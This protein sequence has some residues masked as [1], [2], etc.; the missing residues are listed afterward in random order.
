MYLEFYGT[1]SFHV[2]T[3]FQVVCRLMLNW[4]I[5]NTISESVFPGPPTRR[6]VSC[7]FFVST[8]VSITFLA[9]SEMWISCE[10]LCGI[11]LGSIIRLVDKFGVSYHVVSV[12]AMKRFPEF[13]VVFAVSCPG[14]KLCSA[15]SYTFTSLLPAPS[16]AAAQPVLLWNRVPWLSSR[17][18]LHCPPHCQLALNCP[19]TNVSGMNI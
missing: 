1:S 4:W 2:C 7:L 6:K 10:I 11:N 18:S 17:P 14:T 8:A 5:W 16:L 3:L 19:F 15:P 12:S 9:V 13:S